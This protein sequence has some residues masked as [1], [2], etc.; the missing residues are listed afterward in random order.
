ME[1]LLRLGSAPH[2]VPQRNRRL[3]AANSGRP[4]LTRTENAV[5][6]LKACTT[7][8]AHDPLTNSLG[9]WEEVVP[10]G[11]QRGLSSIF[12][13]FN[14]LNCLEV[15][16]HQLITE[17]ICDI[18]VSWTYPNS[19]AA[20]QGATKRNGRGTGVSA[21]PS[22]CIRHPLVHYAFQSSNQ[23]KRVRNSFQ[24]ICARHPSCFRWAN[25]CPAKKD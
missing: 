20:G 4:F 14:S 12:W 5:L 13:V 11:R 3:I 25:H 17:G 19:W 6:K 18:L 22:T 16:G 8:F 15:L 1:C 21:W 2:L 23:P 7:A 10:L 24:Q 9:T